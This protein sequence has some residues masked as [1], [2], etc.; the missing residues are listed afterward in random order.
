MALMKT[1]NRNTQNENSVIFFYLK[2]KKKSS[3]D[4]IHIHI[5]PLNTTCE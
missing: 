4:Y 2:K 3:T 5:P 1:E